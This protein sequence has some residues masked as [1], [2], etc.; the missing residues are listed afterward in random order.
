[1]VAVGGAEA[2]ADAVPGT[3]ILEP[4]T[5]TKAATRAITATR[6]DRVRFRRGVLSETSPTAAEQPSPLPSPLAVSCSMLDSRLRCQADR[7]V[8]AAP[9]RPCCGLGGRVVQPSYGT[10]AGARKF[11][12]LQFD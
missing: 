7:G 9:P 4:S 10:T 11:D 2:P 8:V 5:V 3:T 6:L 1:M 12:S